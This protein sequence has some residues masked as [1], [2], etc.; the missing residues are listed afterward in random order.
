MAIE[1]EAKLKVDNFTAIRRRLAACAA[2]HKST[3]LELNIFLDTP[4]QTLQHH[5]QGLRIRQHQYLAPSDDLAGSSTPN[6]PHS[7]PAHP[8]DEVIITFKGPRQPGPLKSREELEINVDSLQ[9][10]A[11]LFEHLGYRRTLTFEKRRQS[12]L[13]DGCQIELDELPLLGC[14]VEIE[15]PTE[16]LVLRTQQSLGL[17]HLPTITTSYAALLSEKL[18]ATG[19]PPQTPITF[20]PPTTSPQ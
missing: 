2:Q 10:A 20:T 17:A 16:A 18:K 15:G 6:T 11:S 3:R 5:D 4:D 8:P 7:P 14:F 12:W 1:I 19:L 13:L 9:H